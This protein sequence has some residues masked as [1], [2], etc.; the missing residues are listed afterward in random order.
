[1]E[2]QK[3]EYLNMNNNNLDDDI[4]ELKLF[5]ER[6]VYTNWKHL[7]FVNKTED[8]IIQLENDEEEYIN[9]EEIFYKGILY[10]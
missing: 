5:I 7:N 6:F 9:D 2:Q 1:M 10:I 8:I 3:D 4:F